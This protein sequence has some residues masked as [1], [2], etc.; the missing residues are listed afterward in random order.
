MT[1]MAKLV[2]IIAF[3]I[4]WLFLNNIAILVTTPVDCLLMF[5][6]FFD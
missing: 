1:K 3:F 2:T 6:A 4:L 5:L